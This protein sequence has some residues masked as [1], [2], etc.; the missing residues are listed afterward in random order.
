MNDDSI[1]SREVVRPPVNIPHRPVNYTPAQ[2]NGGG[3]GN[4]SE[5]FREHRKLLVKIGD[6]VQVIDPKS[7]LQGKYGLIQAIHPRNL[8][9]QV[10]V[11]IGKIN[12]PLKFFQIRFCSR[13]D[14]V[15]NGN[16]KKDSA[17]FETEENDVETS[18]VSDFIDE[19]DESDDN[20]GNRAGANE[21]HGKKL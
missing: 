9:Y 3:N 21:M 12:N 17:T 15:N 18:K 13:I 1:N 6:M 5:G 2:G 19:I 20:K 8:Q 11:R 14:P 7:H 16:F 4:S 10:L